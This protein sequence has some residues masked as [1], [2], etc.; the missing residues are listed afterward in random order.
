[1]R[2]M[3]SSIFRDLDGIVDSILSPY[4]TLEEVLPSGCD[5]GPV[6]MDFDCWVDSQK[7]DM[8]TSESPLLLNICGIP[9]SGKS[10]WAEE[11]LLENGPCLH[12]AFDAIM[13]AL[14]G[15]Q[16]DCSLDREKAFLRWELP[17]RFLGY[18]LLLLGLRNGWPIL[19]EHSNALREHVDLYK[20]IKSLG[21][22]IHM[23]CIDATPEMVIKRLARRNRFFPEEQVKKR[24]DCLIDLLPEYQKIVDDFKLIQPWKN[25]ENL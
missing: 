14:S 12:I 24:W 5:A 9:A 2:S 19:F 6:W 4:H 13:E 23:V 17:A 8:R 11:W 18:R 16:A 1:M 22:R 7:V 10:Y 15:Y 25:V 20:K 21:Y 3:E